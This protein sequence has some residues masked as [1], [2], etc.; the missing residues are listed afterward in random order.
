[1]F[2]ENDYGTFDFLVNQ[3]EVL[4][5][6]AR[7]ASEGIISTRYYL[8]PEQFS[9]YE[10]I[11][12]SIARMI[13]SGKALNGQEL[14]NSSNSI[15]PGLTNYKD[16]SYKWIMDNLLDHVDYP[17][18]YLKNEDPEYIK[19]IYE[20][21]PVAEKFRSVSKRGLNGFYKSVVNS[22]NIGIAILVQKSLEDNVDYLSPATDSGIMYRMSIGILLSKKP[23]LLN[24]NEFVGG[25][26]NPT[27]I[28][29]FINKPD[30]RVN[31]NTTGRRAV[32]RRIETIGG[33]IS[34]D[35]DNWSEFDNVEDREQSDHIKKQIPVPSEYILTPAQ[36]L[37]KAKEEYTN[38]KEQIQDENRKIRDYNKKIIRNNLRNHYFQ[39][40]PSTKL[41][42]SEFVKQYNDHVLKFIERHRKEFLD[43][44]RDKSGEEMIWTPGEELKDLPKGLKGTVKDRHGLGKLRPYITVQT[45]AND[46]KQDQ[47]SFQS[48][49]RTT[50]Y[51]QEHPTLNKDEPNYSDKLVQFQQRYDEIKTKIYPIIKKI[52]IA[53][54]GMDRRKIVDEPTTV[55]RTPEQDSDYFTYTLESF[56]LALDNVV[57]YKKYIDVVENQASKQ[58]IDLDDDKFNDYI[59]D[60]FPR[61]DDSVITILRDDDRILS[62]LIKP[63]KDGYSKLEG[64]DENKLKKLFPKLIENQ[65]RRKDII[66]K[67]ISDFR[68]LQ[69]LIKIEDESNDYPG[70]S[71]QVLNSLLTTP[72]TRKAFA[73]WYRVMYKKREYERDQVDKTILSQIRTSDPQPEQEF[74]DF[75]EDKGAEMVSYDFDPFKAF[76]E[77]EEDSYVSKY[78][79]EQ[80]QRDSL[81]KPRGQFVD[82]GFKKVQ[83]Y[84]Q[85]MMRNS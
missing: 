18:T 65:P 46:I 67:I 50:V 43:V 64:I 11:S 38:R 24:D 80:I 36:I 52:N 82:R 1:M 69:G 31:P 53:Q 6:M 66:L 5:E 79:T 42:P 34:G 23:D 62:E 61:L 84:H 27:A 8:T 78:M 12:N 28:A 47:E 44:Q 40:K 71:K 74:E 73:E 48:G 2:K 37:A 68:E 9:K 72:E 19:K 29:D 63:L 57:E 26:L 32:E 16:V 45:L 22:D 59:K 76:D 83:N 13:R 35:Y 75:P 39:F 81:N 14:V 58:G 77:D 7:P 41:T 25:I 3:M 54:R 55:E 4:S 85:W 51:K 30:I 60:E 21:H 10:T 15:V 70:Y 17:T 49:H 56:L 33:K 20:T